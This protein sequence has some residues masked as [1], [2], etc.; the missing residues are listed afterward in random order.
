MKNIR[1]QEYMNT[2]I[3]KYQNTGIKPL[4]LAFISQAGWIPIQS[5]S[6]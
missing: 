3:Q 5:K 1:I 2:R 4:G 6:L